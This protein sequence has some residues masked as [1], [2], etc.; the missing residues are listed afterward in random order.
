MESIKHK[1]KN[2]QDLEYA[3]TELEGTTQEVVVQEQL[4]NSRLAL[5]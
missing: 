4:L 1:H 3:I 5:N 2:V